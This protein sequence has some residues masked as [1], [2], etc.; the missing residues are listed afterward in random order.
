MPTPTTLR[1][2]PAGASTPTPSDPRPARLP[3]DRLPGVIHDDHRGP[4]IQTR[5]GQPFYLRDPRAAEVNVD[6]HT[7]AT[8]LLCRYNGHAARFYSV[9][10]H[11]VRA[12]D[13]YL[14]LAG[15]TGYADPLL[16]HRRA[17]AA[18]ARRVLFHD[19]HE[20]AVGDVTSPQK[21]ALPEFRGLEDP[22]EAVFREAVGMAPGDGDAVECKRIDLLMASIERRDLMDQRGPTWPNL[23]EPPADVAIPRGDPTGLAIRNAIGWLERA[24]RDA[25]SGAW[26]PAQALHDAASALAEALDYQP[27][28]WRGAW[29][30]RWE[31]LCRACRPRPTCATEGAAIASLWAAEARSRGVPDK[32]VACWAALP[33]D[34]D[35]WARHGGSEPAVL[36]A[37]LTRSAT[38]CTPSQA[39][40]DACAA[41]AQ[42]RQAA[43][44]DGAVRAWVAAGCAPALRVGQRVRAHDA[45]H[46]AHV[47]EVDA[48]RAL[49]RPAPGAEWLPADVWLGNEDVLPCD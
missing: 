2:A 13:L 28:A 31:A 23:P 7:W 11:E 37:A 35:W 32:E 39:L 14:R 1:P 36:F 20:G 42:R 9:L 17:C 38:G 6:D 45:D 4:A 15:F 8:S 24:A 5:S 40:Y 48:E 19:H 27:D 21:A 3:A 10:E 46:R 43:C 33:D 12:C 26:S 22:V 25:E 49:W 18:T 34:D 16:L 41:T 47:R 29:N 44:V 30:A